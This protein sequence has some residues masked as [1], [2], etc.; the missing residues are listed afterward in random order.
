MIPA[1]SPPA[2]VVRD[3]RATTAEKVT[4]AALSVIDLVQTEKWLHEPS[5]TGTWAA[6]PREENP[7]LGSHPSFLRMAATGVVLDEAI[8]HVRSPFLRRLSIGVEGS[9]VVRNLFVMKVK[10]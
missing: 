7:L 3:T 9:N 8:L 2:I 5:P 6:P 4:L 1:D 10:V